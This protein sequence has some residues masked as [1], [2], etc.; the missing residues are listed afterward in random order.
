M[1]GCLRDALKTIDVMLLD[2]II[3]TLSDSLSFQTRGLL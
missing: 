1:T 3:V 2:H